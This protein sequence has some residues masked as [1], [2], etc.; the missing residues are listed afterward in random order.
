MHL[1]IGEREIAVSGRLGEDGVLEAALDG[2]RQRARVAWDGLRLTLEIDGV[3]QEL[4]LQDALAAVGEGEAGGNRLIAPMPGKVVQVEVAPGARVAR[5]DALMALE[6]MKMEHTILAPMD[7]RVA[8]VHY[9]AGDL[10][11]EGV[12]L[13]DLEAES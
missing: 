9:R 1:G 8:A 7:G 10:V 13:M 3:R 5:G 6:A 12:D 2:R 11:E 4:S